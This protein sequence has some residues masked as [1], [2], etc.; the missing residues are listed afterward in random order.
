[1][2]VLAGYPLCEP[3]L[4][5]GFFFKSKCQHRRRCD[6]KVLNSSAST[7][8]SCI[9]SNYEHTSKI[10]NRGLVARE[11]KGPEYPGS[12]QGEGPMMVGKD[13]SPGL[14]KFIA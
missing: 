1:M 9:Y 12:R 8:R 13:F 10:S 3:L 11:K 6:P 7:V 14:D 5:G 4:D 2:F